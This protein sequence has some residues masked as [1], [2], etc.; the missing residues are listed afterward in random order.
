MPRTRFD[1]SQQAPRRPRPGRRRFGRAAILMAVLL[2]GWLASEFTSRHRADEERSRILEQTNVAAAALDPEE[3]AALYGTPQEEELPVYA[4]LRTKLQAVHRAS[5]QSRWTYLM[6]QRD[7]R[8]LFTVDSVPSGHPDHASCGDGYTD[9]PGELV[10]VFRDGKARV[11]GPYRDRWGTFVSAFVPVMSA[12]AGQ[13]VAVLGLD[14]DVSQWNRTIMA[15]RRIPLFVALVACLALV[16]IFIVSDRSRDA[17][18]CIARSETNLRLLMESAAEAIFLLDADT[19]RFRETNRACGQLF[20]LSREEILASGPAEVSPP[21]QPD[22]R[23]S[24]EAARER[25]EMALQSGYASFPWVH[26]HRNG[27]PIYCD[28]RLTRLISP[29]QHLLRAS[30]LDTTQQVRL[31]R[32]VRELQQSLHRAGLHAVASRVLG[33]IAAEIGRSASAAEASAGSLRAAF[34][35]L[36]RLLNLQ[37]RAIDAMREDRVTPELIDEAERSFRWADPIRAEIPRVLRTTR[38]E[39]RS[40]AELAA[41][42]APF[43]P[44]GEETQFDLNAVA[45]SAAAVSR[46]LWKGIAEIEF[47]LEQGLPPIS[48][49]T[50]DTHLEVLGLLLKAINDLRRDLDHELG[51]RGTITF[52]TRGAGSYAELAIATSRTGNPFDPAHATVST[53]PLVFRAPIAEVSDPDQAAA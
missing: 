49:L 47:D 25:I 35:D 14:I 21:V 45:T 22:G 44:P 3:C 10:D 1:S 29:G 33:E 4:S 39:L 20:G 17:T 5:R 37:Q 6:V 23:P 42:V 19:M 32:E 7:G 27:S 16:G 36:D 43:V 52:R 50:T 28:V 34:D 40:M 11:V 24:S 51:D 31:E 48:A 12:D 26:R 13:P 9:A 2:G 8:V 53:P 46:Q 38:C 18:A 30:V 15:G 41:S